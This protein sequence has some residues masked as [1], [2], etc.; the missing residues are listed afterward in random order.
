MCQT[1]YCVSGSLGFL[2]FCFLIS[3]ATRT[4]ILVCRHLLCGETEALY[5][6][7]VPSQGLTAQTCP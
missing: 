3:P 1:P 6:I 5:S 4:H 2:G 7:K